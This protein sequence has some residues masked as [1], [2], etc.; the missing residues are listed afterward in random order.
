MGQNKHILVIDKCVFFHKRIKSKYSCFF[1]LLVEKRKLK[2]S[3]KDVYDRIICFNENDEECVW[4]AMAVSI[5]EIQPIDM[6][7]CLNESLQ[8]V[9]AKIAERIGIKYNSVMSYT[10]VNNKDIMRKYLKQKGL[11]NIFYSVVNGRND[12]K[13]FYLSQKRAII[14]KPINGTGSA[15]IIKIASVD[16]VDNLP[17]KFKQ[18]MLA[19]TFAQGDE[20]SVEAISYNGKNKV[21]CITQKFKDD[22]NFVEKG[23]IV[24]AKISKELYERIANYVEKV[25]ESIGV[26]TGVTHTEVIASSEEVEIVETHIRIGGDYI[27]EIIENASGVNLFELQAALTMNDELECNQ[28]FNLQPLS[29]GNQKCFSMVGFKFFNKTG[30]IKK[31]QNIP[32]KEDDRN[33]ILVNVESVGEKVHKTCDSFTR[34]M[35]IIVKGKT[36]SECV[37]TCENYINKLEY[38]IEKS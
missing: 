23:H 21:L 6:I 22:S 17:P 2:S 32:K 29:V 7:L 20:Y 13:Q 33:L 12:V 1:S 5:N 4:E 35:M 19:E 24:P 8:I 38:T 26:Y 37:E 3:D 36:H 14:V 28:L 27:P 10:I 16:E 30:V 25:L 31:I 15:N 9:A 34:G 18:E 11:T